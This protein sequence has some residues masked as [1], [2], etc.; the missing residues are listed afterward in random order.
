MYR[1]RIPTTEPAEPSKWEDPYDVQDRYSGKTGTALGAYGRQC[2]DCTGLNF[3]FWQGTE[4]AF[5]GAWR[6]VDATDGWGDIT[7]TKDVQKPVS[8]SSL[9]VSH[10]PAASGTAS[11]KR[12]ISSTEKLRRAVRKD[13]RLFRRE[14]KRFYNNYV[15]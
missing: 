9:A 11:I 12:E 15:A 7:F 13:Y 2:D 6:T 8:N 5:H 4:G 14:A 3:F 1:S 10:V